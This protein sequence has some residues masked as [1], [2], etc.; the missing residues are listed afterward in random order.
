MAGCGLIA[1]ATGW[2]M[3]SGPQP[4]LRDAGTLRTHAARGAAA[5]DDSN[6]ASP[7][8]KIRGP[9]GFQAAVVPV[10]S[11]RDGVLT[12]PTDPRTGGWWALG[13]TVGAPHGT[14]LIAGHVDTRDAGLG[15]FAA[16]HRMD[17]GNRV[18]VTGADGQVRAYRI[19]ARRSYRQERLPGDLFTP[20][21]DHRLA[22]I[23]CG[24]PYDRQA[25]RYEMNLVLYG[26]PVS[27]TLPARGTAGQAVLGR[28]GE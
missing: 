18:E 23:T 5:A 4:S 25:G 19:T 3:C 27:T 7:P 2:L 26:T 15:M 1:M 20:G 10:A 6:N 9:N 21:G 12:L 13:A 17:L 24:G 28:M 14:V 22:L 16:L 11:T 8:Q